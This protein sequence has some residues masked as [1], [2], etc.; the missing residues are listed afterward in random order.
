M[1]YA[2]DG[3]VTVTEQETAFTP[4]TADVAVIVAVPSPTAVTLPF[5]STVATFVFELNHVTFFESDVFSGLKITESD[6]DLPF[7]S[8]ILVADKDIFLSGDTTVT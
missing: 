8:E 2:G 5:L 6:L 4:L 7:S 1:V 3:V